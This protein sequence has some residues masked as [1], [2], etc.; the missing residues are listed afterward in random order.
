MHYCET[1]NN[2]P[3]RRSAGFPPTRVLDRRNSRP[4]HLGQAKTGVAG[5][6]LTPMRVSTLRMALFVSG[7]P[8]CKRRK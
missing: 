4:G 7:V 5:A 2:L 6:V 1:P 8:A 3:G